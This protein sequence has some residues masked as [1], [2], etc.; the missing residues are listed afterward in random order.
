[1]KLLVLITCHNR[2]DKTKKCLSSLLEALSYYEIDC[3]IVVNDDGSTD[4]TAEM[5]Q[6]EF[7]TVK[8]VKSDGSY[9]WN[10]GMINAWEN[11]LELDRDF[12]LLLNDDVEL[13]PEALANLVR[14]YQSLVASDKKEGIVVGACV[15]KETGE[16]TYGGRID[17]KLLRP[18]GKIQNCNIINGNVVLIP[19]RVTHEIGF[20]SPA[21]T[22]AMGDIDFG[23]RALEHGFDV[24]VSSEYVGYCET[25]KE[26][27][28]VSPEVSLRERW[29]LF[30]S[31]KGLNIKEYIYF[32][33][34]H[35][36]GTWRSD[37]L[38]A[39][40]RMLAPA[41]YNWLSNRW[42]QRG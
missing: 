34:K 6:N 2:K 1:M 4:G 38:K 27:N 13:F 11:S 41:I 16:C 17:D 35:W 3:N 10:K 22:H 7:P 40:C 33:K 12:T 31:P 5:I 14:D 37:V 26:L 32:R 23:L 15:S 21:Y 18:I 24:V 20:L 28:W 9:F 19:K 39:Y 30:H 25:N 8:V 42:L 36:P 29:Q